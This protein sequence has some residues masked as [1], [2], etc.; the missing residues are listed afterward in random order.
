MYWSEGGKTPKIQRAHMTGSNQSVV[1][2]LSSEATGLALDKRANLLY[3][4]ETEAKLIRYF[5]LTDDR[6]GTLIQNQMHGP[7]HL[8]LHGDYL[9]WTDGDLQAVYGG[10]YRVYRS[11]DLSAARDN[12]TKIVDLQRLPFGI[13]AHSSRESTNPG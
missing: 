8:T 13:Q 9:Y 12:I 2:N 7:N 3:W 6:L 10:V 4:T 1:T 5:N 11:L